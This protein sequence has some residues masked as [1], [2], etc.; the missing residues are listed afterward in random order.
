MA[1][2]NGD[3]GDGAVVIGLD[4]G[5]TKIAAAV[6]DLSGRRLAEETVETGGHDRPEAVLAR[7]IHAAQRLLASV[8][9][10]RRPAAVGAATFGIPDGDRIHLAPTVAGWGEVALEAELRRA[11]GDAEV[12]VSTD[13]KAAAGA[14]ARWGALAGCDPGVYLN[15]GTGLAAAIVVDGRVLRGAHGASGEIGYNLRDVGDVGVAHGT[16]TLLEDAV[17]GRALA[18][19]SAAAGCS[20][21]EVFALAGH[22]PSAAALLRS[23]L[24]ELCLH[25]VNLCIAVDPARV[26]VGGGM[27]NSWDRLGPVLRAALD[28]GAPFPP[29]LVVAAFPFD[30]PLRGALALAVQAASARN[31]GATA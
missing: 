30:A 19:R 15:L 11:F 4:F 25:V 23:F 7:G 5:G 13:V 18:R 27:V 17:S 28:A 22:D 8:A 1:E 31:G 14:E 20:A 6:S 3:R 10:G 21:A 29:E 26:A 9:P 24:D 12:R 2:T 16:R